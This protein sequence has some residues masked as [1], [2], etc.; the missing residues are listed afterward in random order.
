[1][2]YRNQTDLVLLEKKTDNVSYHIHGGLFFLG[3][4]DFFFIYSKASFA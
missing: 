4:V 3:F 1:M 2:F